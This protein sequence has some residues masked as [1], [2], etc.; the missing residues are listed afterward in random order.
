MKAILTKY[1]GPT[2][3]RGSR[4]KA[5][6]EDGNSITIPFD[7]GLNQGQRHK[8]AAIALCKKMGWAGEMV[9]GGIKN[10]YAFC[11]V[12][13]WVGKGLDDE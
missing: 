3:H 1:I 6:D 9:G 11:F 13:S 7:Y 5:Y 8:K 12:D 10:G 4:I 2:L